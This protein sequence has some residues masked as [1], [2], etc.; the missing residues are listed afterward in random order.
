MKLKQLLCRHRYYDRDVVTYNDI[1]KNGYI[2][3]NRCSKCGKAYKV[4]ISAD[5]VNE[6]IEKDLKEMHRGNK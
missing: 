5:K 3:Y 4:F 6:W 2:L 1:V